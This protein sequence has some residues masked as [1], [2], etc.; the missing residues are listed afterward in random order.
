MREQ[1]GYE[2]GETGCMFSST[3]PRKILQVCMSSLCIIWKIKNVISRAGTNAIKH[4]RRRWSSGSSRHCE[5]ERWRPHRLEGKVGGGGSG[6]GGAGGGRG[7]VAK[8]RVS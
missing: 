2:L 6:G 4:A 1:R 8:W 7:E 3:V 5:A